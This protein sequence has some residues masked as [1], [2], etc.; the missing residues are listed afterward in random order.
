M[1]KTFMAI[2][3]KITVLVLTVNICVLFFLNSITIAVPNDSSAVEENPGVKLALFAQAFFATNKGDRC[4]YNYEPGVK[5]SSETVQETWNTYTHGVD[6]NSNYK[7]RFE[8]TGFVACMIYWSL[9]LYFPSVETGYLPVDVGGVND[10]EHFTLIN[11]VENLYAGDIL[12]TLG[13]DPH[14]AIYVGGGMMVDMGHSGV[15]YRGIHSLESSGIVFKGVARLKS[16]EGATQPPIEG[17][18]D[19]TPTPGESSGGTGE[20]TKPNPNLHYDA[21]SVDLDAEKFDFDFNGMP[22]TAINAGGHSIM[23]YIE[24]IGDAFDYLFGIILN[25]FKVVP[26]GIIVGLEN[27][28]TDIFNSLNTYTI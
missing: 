18:T 17:G 3:R 8:C 12:M 9:G 23:Y 14:V 27:W 11:S 15:E 24:K 25:G 2:L 19:I 20:T 5:P 26:V 16:V 7:Y 10:T 21:P 4:I 28:I 13:G 6:N 1:G 22:K